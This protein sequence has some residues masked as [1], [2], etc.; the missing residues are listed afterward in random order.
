[1]GNVRIREKKR[2][3]VMASISSSDIV[4]AKIVYEHTVDA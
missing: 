1:M 2:C 4:R 3:V